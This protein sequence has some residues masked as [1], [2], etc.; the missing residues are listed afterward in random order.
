MGIVSESSSGMVVIGVVVAGACT[1]GPVETLARTGKLPS[2]SDCVNDDSVDGEDGID[3]VLG[4]GVRC[5]VKS[6]ASMVFSLVGVTLWN[7]PFL[8]CNLGASSR[9]LVVAAC[10]SDLAPITRWARL[11]DVLTSPARDSVTVRKGRMMLCLLPHLGPNH[12]KLSPNNAKHAT[13]RYNTASGCATASRHL[14]RNS[15]SEH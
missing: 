10:G 8:A 15:D 1:G 9:S 12:W 6:I 7:L 3:G 14:I 4:G 2:S 11:P 13:A 5:V